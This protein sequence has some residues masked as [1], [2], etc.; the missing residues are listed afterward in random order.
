MFS[1][2][3]MLFYTTTGDAWEA[4]VLHILINTF[5]YLLNYNYPYRH[6]VMSDCG[7]DFNFLV[8]ND[9]E[10]LFMSL[11]VTYKSSL[12]KYLIRSFNSI[13]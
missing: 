7:F 5:D 3:V 11:L 6:E 10:H 8:A 13:F 4:H 9:V 2:K 1:D 12:E